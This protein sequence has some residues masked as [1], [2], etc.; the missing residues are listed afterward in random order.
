M[1]G[2]RVDAG[3]KAAAPMFAALGDETRLRL[4][5]RLRAGGPLSITSLAAGTRITRQAVTKH[6]NVLAAAGLA[7][8]RRAGRERK[9][10]LNS[11]RLDEARRCLSIISRQW[12]DALSRLKLAV[13]KD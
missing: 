7:S 8:S 11:S 12:E 5:T 4:V 13:E 6:L 2:G 3:F 9:W 1:R 10:E